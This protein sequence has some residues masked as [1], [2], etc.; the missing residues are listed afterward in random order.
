TS[1][2][3]MRNGR[4]QCR[5]FSCTAGGD[6]GDGDYGA[7]SERRQGETK[8]RGK[9]TNTPQAK[10]YYHLSA[11]N[12]STPDA[13]RVGTRNQDYEAGSESRATPVMVAGSDRADVEQ[14][15]RE[16]AR[17]HERQGDPDC[18]ADQDR[19]QAFPE[20]HRQYTGSSGAKR[21]PDSNFACLLRDRKRQHRVNANSE[22]INAS[23]ANTESSTRFWPREDMVSALSSAAVLML[24]IGRSRSRERMTAR[25]AAAA[26][27]GASCPND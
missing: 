23:A 4:L 19:Q 27:S 18:Q 21:H 3:E 14:H 16:H 13:R 24:A 9:K 1:L 10:T 7:R 12:G 17:G 25:T 26:R 20:H 22:R 11:K 15:L 6:G 2:R 5:P 8:T